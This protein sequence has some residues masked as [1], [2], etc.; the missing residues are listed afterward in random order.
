MMSH[1]YEKTKIISN[2]VQDSLTY[3]I[4]WLRKPGITI[5]AR[6]KSFQQGWTAGWG[7]A[8]EED[9]G[10]QVDIYAARKGYT[11]SGAGGG[12]DIGHKPPE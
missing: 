1:L 2:K 6:L 9:W 3:N 11:G 5:R 7:N 12:G 4:L 8:A 10:G